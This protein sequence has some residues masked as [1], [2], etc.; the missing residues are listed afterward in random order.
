MSEMAP[1]DAGFDLSIR[2]FG[3]A[4][5]GARARRGV[6]AACRTQRAGR[7]CRRSFFG[8]LWRLCGRRI[9]H[10]RDQSSFGVKIF[11]PKIKLTATC[12]G[13]PVFIGHSEAINIEF[14][15]PLSA[16]EAREIL[17]NA[18]GCLVID[19]RESG[20]CVTPHECAGE[21]ET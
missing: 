5:G 7:Q 2:G 1:L 16:E 18:A 14:E 21:D 10:F 15:E 3:Q 6:T 20:G 17:R 13:V 9:S 11:D 4:S 19:K 8:C 12:V